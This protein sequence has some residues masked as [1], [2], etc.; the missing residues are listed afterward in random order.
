ML[1]EDASSIYNIDDWL[2]S[3]FLTLENY[4]SLGLIFVSSFLLADGG[5][6]FAYV[7]V[8]VCNVE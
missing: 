1:R 6:I 8:L 3:F 7:F 2:T 5:Y 4:T